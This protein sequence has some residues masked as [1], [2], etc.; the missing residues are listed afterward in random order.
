VIDY[1]KYT[2]GVIPP[3]KATRPKV[4]RSMLKTAR[5]H[6]IAGDHGNAWAILKA[7]RRGTFERP[8]GFGPLYRRVR[9]AITRS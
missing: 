4:I 3:R 5:K 2:T 8:R 7:I 1:C 6:H 9:R